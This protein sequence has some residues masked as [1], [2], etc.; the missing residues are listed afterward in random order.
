MMIREILY[1]TDFSEPARSA[2]HYATMI[3]RIFGATLH[4][5]HVP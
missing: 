2:G 1:P 4:I 5:L 3:A